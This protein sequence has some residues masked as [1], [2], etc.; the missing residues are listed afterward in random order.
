MRRKV[1]RALRDAD[2]DAVAVENPAHPG[3]PDVNYAGGWIELKYLP[4]WPA[5]GGVVRIRHF[6][7]QQRIWL[8]RRRDAGG[9]AYLLL[10]VGTDW[11]LLDGRDAARYVGR[12]GRKKL[13][14]LALHSTDSWS[15]MKAALPNSLSLWDGA[16]L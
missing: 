3:T 16:R 6:S 11:L 5:K 1:V 12:V 4:A 10:Q 9:A 8:E 2:L 15:K 13:L 7:K 14:N